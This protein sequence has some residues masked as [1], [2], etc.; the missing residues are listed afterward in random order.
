MLLAPVTA[1]VLAE[2]NDF[3]PEA[4]E[5]QEAEG[6]S[7]G[8]VLSPEEGSEA[9]TTDG[10]S[11]NALR[12]GTGE[13][14]SINSLAGSSSGNDEDKVGNL[15]A[16]TSKEVHDFVVYPLEGVWKQKQGGVLVKE[17]LNTP[18]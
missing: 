16:G 13:G 14:E 12:T 15:D 17:E 7:D 2:E 6:F 5:T 3:L 9:G 1:N 10:D 11:G 4:T 18:L 8:I